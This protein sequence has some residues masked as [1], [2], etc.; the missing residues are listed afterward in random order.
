MRRVRKGFKF[1]ND[2]G[3]SFEVIAIKGEVCVIQKCSGEI[4]SMGQETLQ[5]LLNAKVITPVIPQIGDATTQ[6]HYCFKCNEAT[7]IT[8]DRF[9]DVSHCPLC[10]SSD[11]F[12]VSDLDEEETA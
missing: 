1:L 10:G 12:N 4:F 3:K 2:I 7:I 5:T 6:T 8:H 9:D 11:G